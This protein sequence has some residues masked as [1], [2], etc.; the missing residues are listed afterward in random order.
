M[1]DAT[2]SQVDA[3]TR[4]LDTNVADAVDASA[5]F[6]A[7]MGGRGNA[8]SNFL[9]TPAAAEIPTPVDQCQYHPGKPRQKVPAVL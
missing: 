3:T 4:L 5:L 6:N 8:G 9:N 2:T 1:D 7:A